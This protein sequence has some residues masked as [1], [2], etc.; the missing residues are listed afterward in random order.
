MWDWNVR[1]NASTPVSSSRQTLYM[2]DVELAHRLATD[3]GKLALR[4]RA[5]SGLGPVQ[6]AITESERS[7]RRQLRDAA[8]RA[9][10]EF[11]LA[12]L[13]AERPADAVLSEEGVDDP[14]R[15]RAPRLW[16]VDPVDGTWEFGQGR[17]D[18]AVHVALWDARA[19]ALTAGAV[20]IPAAGLTYDTANPP[21]VDESPG[22]VIRLVVS[23]SRPPAQLDRIV[24]ELSARFERSVQ[25]YNVGSAGAKT[26]E[27]LAGKADAYV[28]DA[29][30]SE[31]D[32]AAPAAVAL[33][34]GLHVTHL[35]GSPINYNW[36]IPLVGDLV[37]GRRSVAA[38]IVELAA[39][40]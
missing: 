17:P 18:F 5:E 19:R 23:R 38:A 26:A 40:T 14:A 28:H 6:G 16:I 31:W 12:A 25:T 29:G 10:H 39:A 13:S 34:A 20:A 30:L 35:D 3:A 22:P 11:L 2:N 32:V 36:P 7:A 24:S 33:A 8:D 21:V 9:C 27:V 1:K 37:I 4:V 15:L